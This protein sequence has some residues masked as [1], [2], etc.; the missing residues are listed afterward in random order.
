MKILFTIPDCRF[1]GIAKENLHFDKVAYTEVP[2]GKILAALGLSGMMLDVV[3]PILMSEEGEFY[4]LAMT[5]PDKWRFVRMQLRE[6][7]VNQLVLSF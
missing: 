5:S 4:T 6:N 2:I 3:A 1:C 7:P